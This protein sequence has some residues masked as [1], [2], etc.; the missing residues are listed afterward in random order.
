MY[1]VSMYLYS[2]VGEE[3]DKMFICNN[4]QTTLIDVC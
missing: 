2:K 1:L 3:E 4:V